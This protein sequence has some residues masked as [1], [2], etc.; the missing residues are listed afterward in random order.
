MRA[1]LSPWEGIRTECRVIS[2][3]MLRETITRYG[4]HDVGVLWLLFEPMLFTTGV[5]ALWDLVFPH[6]P[7]SIPMV[8]IAITGY[9]CILLWRN[10]VGHSTHSIRPNTALLYHRPVRPIDCLLARVGLEV[11]GATASFAIL[12]FFFAFI[13]VI[14]WPEDLMPVIVGWLLMCWWAMAM[15]MILCSAA[16]RSE[17]AG[18]IWNIV[19]YLLMPVSGAAYMVYWLPP[20]Y[21]EWALLIPMVHG[22]ELIRLGFFGNTVPTFG[23]PYYFACSN[24]VATLLG[25]AM[26]RDI[27]S[28]V[29]ASW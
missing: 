17:F 20:S 27:S 3:L 14:P 19:S 4:R 1:A 23:N 24:L 2:A 9:S 10:T 8:G 22:T 11:I 26:M 28:K 29:Q 16:E 6:A 7:T 12:T 18:R 13:E 15:A 25:L 21:R 5:I